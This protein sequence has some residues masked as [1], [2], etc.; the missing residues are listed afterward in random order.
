MVE[1]ITMEF[2][3][4]AGNLPIRIAFYNGPTTKLPKY[5]IFSKVYMIPTK[6]IGDYQPLN[7]GIY[8]YNISMYRNIISHRSIT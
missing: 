5:P 4:T 2:R 6:R 1:K 7:I 8:R 3:G